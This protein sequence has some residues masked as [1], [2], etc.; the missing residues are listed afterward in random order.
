MTELVIR[1]IHRNTK[2]DSFRLVV[3]DNGSSGD[4]PDKLQ[5]LADNGWID[6]YIPIKTNLGLEAARNL[7]LKNCTQ[8]RRFVCVDNDCLPP[9][10]NGSDWLQK[11]N[12]LM[13][14]YE[15]Y[16][17]ISMRTSPMIGTG[18]IFEAAEKVG[19]DIV[20]FPHPGGSYRIMDT[21]VT[22]FVGGWDREASGRGSEETYICGKLHDAGYKT[23]FAVDIKSLHLFG[24]EGTDNWGYDKKMKPEDSGHSSGVWHPKFAEGDDPEEVEAYVGKKLAQWYLS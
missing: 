12:N 10:T 4:T 2:R 13:D 20:L 9:P 24:D 15:D 21:G 14:K 16:A 3:L 22:H 8:S 11:L 7:L 17:A 18:N 5:M 6:E 19:D 1:A 23:A